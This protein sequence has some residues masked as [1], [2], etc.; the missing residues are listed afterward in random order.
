[1]VLNSGLSVRWTGQFANLRVCGASLPEGNRPMRSNLSVKVD[2][3]VDVAAIL[4][5]VT[6]LLLLLLT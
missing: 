1:M 5:R 3:K 6:L 2:V 4:S